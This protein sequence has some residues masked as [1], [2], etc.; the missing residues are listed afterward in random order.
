VERA[1]D[2]VEVWVESG[3]EPAMRTYN[4]WDASADADANNAPGA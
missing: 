4:R 1:A 3:L 2:A